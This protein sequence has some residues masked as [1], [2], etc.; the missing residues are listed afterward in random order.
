MCNSVWYVPYCKSVCF[1]SK[2]GVSEFVVC[3]SMWFVHT[4]RVC[5]IYEFVVFT[6]RVCGV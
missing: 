4:V 6:V 2:C 1:V 3:K 5:G